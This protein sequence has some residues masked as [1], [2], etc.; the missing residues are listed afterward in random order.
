MKNKKKEFNY[1]RAITVTIIL[2]ICLIFLSIVASVYT[3]VDY[4]NYQRN[5]EIEL[6][7]WH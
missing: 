3:L 7:R 4:Y 6:K 1:D 5:Q 2:F